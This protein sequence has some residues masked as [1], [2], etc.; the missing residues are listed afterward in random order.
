MKEKDLDELT[1]LW[2]EAK[3]NARQSSLDVTAVRKAGESRK[4][5]TLFAHYGNAAVLSGTVAVLVFFF[6]YLYNFHD[7]LSIIGYNLMIGGL[8]LRIIIEFFS[9]WRSTKIKFSDT[10]TTSLQYLLSFLEFRKRIHGPITIVIFILYFIGF[11]M[12]TPEFSRYISFKWLVIFDVSA[13]FIAVM[14]M[15]FIRRGIRQEMEHLENMIS[16][17][18]SLVNEG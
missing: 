14:L 3:T 4:K 6:Y 11:Y 9:A 10:T 15:Y 13:L 8:V 5:S 7:T 12:L 17:H 1:A 18:R 16:I 2:Q